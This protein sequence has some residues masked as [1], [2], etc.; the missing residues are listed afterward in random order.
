VAWLRAKETAREDRLFADPYARSFVAAAAAKPAVPVMSSRP[1]R[2]DFYELMAEQV[3]LRTRFLDDALLDAAKNT[4]AQVVLLACGMDTRA[5]RLSWPAGTHVFEVDLAETLAFKDS[6]LAEQGAVAT[7]ERTTV[8]ADLRHDWPAQL[9]AADWQARQPTLWLA[10]GIWYALSADT[11]DFLL[12]RITTRSAPGSMLAFDHNE[13]SDLLRAARAAIS[14]ELVDLWLGG[15][16]EEPGTW[17]RRH[18]WQPCVQDIAAVA[19]RYGRPTPPPFLTDQH[20]RAWLVTAQVTHRLPAGS[21]AGGLITTGR[22][23]GTT[24]GSKRAKPSPGSK[25]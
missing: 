17:L 14:P 21:K 15:P 25:T 1:R 6:V 16:T 23:A 8:A 9:A 3:A 2:P 10:E 24:D 12:Q 22:C 5:F 7:C 19:T 4:A 18:G 20:A 11:A 13:D